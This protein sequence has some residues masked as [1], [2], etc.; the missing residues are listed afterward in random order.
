MSAAPSRGA[1]RDDVLLGVAIHQRR[2][3]VVS[4][5]EVLRARPLEHPRVDAVPAGLR[6]PVRVPAAE[7]VEVE[8]EAGALTRHHS[9][10]R[11]VHHLQLPRAHAVDVPRAAA[12]RAL[13]HRRPR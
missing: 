12:D 13:T 1:K 11:L 10:A 9:A 8:G 6:R 7:G 4:V 3:R 2:R 5:A